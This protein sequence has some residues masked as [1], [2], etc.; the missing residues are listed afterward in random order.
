[1]PVD[2]R[3]LVLP[4]QLIEVGGEVLQERR[5]LE[6]LFQPFLTQLVIPHAGCQPRHQRL[7]FDAMT[8]DDRH[9]DPLRLFEDR[10][11]QVGGFDRVPTETARMQQRQLEQQLRGRRDSHV[12][13]RRARQQPEVLFE[14]LQNLVRVQLDVAHYLAEHVPLDLG[15]RETDMLVGQERMVPPASLVEGTVEDSLGRLSQLVLGDVEVFH[16]ALHSKSCPSDSK[17]HASS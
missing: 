7:G 13:S 12:T 10:R 8:T 15:E 3:H 11:E 5:Q 6:P 2:R 4:R 9:R 16:G 14:R 1:M 17:G